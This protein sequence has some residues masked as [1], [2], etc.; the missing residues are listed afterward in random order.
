MSIT[1]YVEVELGDVN[2]NNLQQLK[3]LNICTLPVRY[4]V[5]NSSHHLHMPL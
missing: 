1:R 4:G 2:A 5:Q 3:I